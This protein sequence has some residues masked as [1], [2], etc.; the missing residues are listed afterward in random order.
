MVRLLQTVVK[1]AVAALIVG[2]ILAH[3]GITLDTLGNELGISTARIRE[4]VQQGVAWALPNLVLG[5]V[6]I[7]PL[8]FIVYILRPPGQS[9]E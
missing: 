1:I 6:V 8:W 9:R 5:L 2:T 4:L 7:I 3:F